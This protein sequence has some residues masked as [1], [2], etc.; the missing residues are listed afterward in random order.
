MQLKHPLK[1][2]AVLALAAAVGTPGLAAAQAVQVVTIGHVAPMSGPQAPFGKDM[3]NGAQMAVDEVNAQHP[4]IAGKHVRFQIDAEDDAADPKQATDVAQKLCDAKVAGV[5]GHL[6]SGATI[7]A[8]RIYHD[9]GIPHVTGAATNPDLTKPGW[10][11]TYRIIANDNTLG[12]GLAK[13]A[14]DT[15]HLKKVAVIDDRTAYGE[16]LADIF[17]KVAK[18]R[19]M[20]VVD[21]EYT[22]DKATDFM[23]ILTAIKGKAPDSIFYGGMD[24][25]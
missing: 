12:A 25:Q 11:T 18:E 14:A 13:Y 15:M 4:V 22:T 6:N 8:A 19:G 5:V 1:M 2:A 21:Q 9:C 17:A 23:A 20:Q 7:P 10:N 16:G 24:P 3:L